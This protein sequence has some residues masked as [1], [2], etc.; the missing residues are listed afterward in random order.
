MKSI[1]KFHD[2]Y[3][4]LSNFYPSVVHDNHQIEYPTVEHAFQAAKVSTTRLR[5]YIACLA[6]PNDAKKY[7][8]NVELRTDWEEVKYQI[9][10]DLVL[11]KFRHKKLKKLLL[12]TQGAKLI[13]GNTWHDTTWGRCNCKICNNAGT[14]Y[15]GKIL[16]LVREKL[17]AE[18]LI[19]YD[20]N[21]W[22]TDKDI[23]LITK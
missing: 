20:T 12:D 18:E 15:L 4:F 21:R 11:Q 2:D 10:Y 6:K 8:G 17:V 19:K 14:N 16:M 9:M 7:G 13:E 3:E 1:Q 22:F 23:T 5:K